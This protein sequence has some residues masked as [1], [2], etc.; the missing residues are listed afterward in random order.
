MKGCLSWVSLPVMR[1]A[2]TGFLLWPTGGNRGNGFHEGLTHTADNLLSL[3]LNHS[4]QHPNVNSI[5]TYSTDNKPRNHLM[6][7]MLI[8]GDNHKSRLFIVLLIPPNDYMAVTDRGCPPGPGAGRGS[9]QAWPPRRYWW[10]S[11]QKPASPPL[12]PKDLASLAASAPL[13]WGEDN[14]MY[15]DW[16]LH[17]P[18][19]LK[20][21]F[22]MKSSWIVIGWTPD[23]S[24]MW[25][26]LLLD[27][28]ATN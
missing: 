18:T 1:P 27:I 19:S 23:L 28:T 9:A 7:L 2:S 10:R 13:H 16:N 5:F 12:Q 3:M 24:Y 22:L 21:P 8:I 4:N 20:H 14:I 17:G 25:I 11:G 6:A 15:L 26:C